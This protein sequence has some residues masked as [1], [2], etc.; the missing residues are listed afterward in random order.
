MKLVQKF[1]HE[2]PKLVTEELDNLTATI[3]ATTSVEHKPDG[4]HGDVTCDSLT[5]TGA[6]TAGAISADAITAT[7]AIT[8]TG[9]VTATGG[10]YERGRTV[11]M[12]E[13]IDV[14]FSAANFTANGTMT[15]TVA[16]GDQVIYRYALVGKTVT[17][18]L[19]LSTTSIG[20]TVNT[21]LYLAL[22]AALTPA[23]DART[24][25]HIYNGAGGWRPGV[26]MV[27]AGVA[28]IAVLNVDQVT[29]WAVSTDTTYV[30]GQMIFEMQ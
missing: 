19:N 13:W 24:L 5:V 8:T 9:T 29:T 20:G 10:V 16:A 30:V 11:A 18:N 14:P 17:V 3:S 22:P 26:A 25:L 12:G 27:A 7:G 21:T 2:L 28:R 4:T 1:R 6:L 23:K 15:W